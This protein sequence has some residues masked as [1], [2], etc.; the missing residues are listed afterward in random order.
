MPEVLNRK[1]GKGLCADTIESNIHPTVK[2]IALMRYLCRLITPPG[3]TILDPFTGSGTTLCA[4]V[5]EGFDYVGCEQEPEYIAIA[6]RRVAYFNEHGEAG[7]VYDAEPASVH[8]N[9][10]GL[11]S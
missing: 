5:L 8:E 11:F 1:S 9:Q 4:A 6:E 3:G 2:P 10:G 7:L